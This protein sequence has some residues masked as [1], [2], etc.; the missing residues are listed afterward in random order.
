MSTQTLSSTQ[1]REIISFDPSNG[2]EIGRAPLMTAT[3]VAAA[4]KRTR[5]AQP[6]WSRLSFPARARYI[7]RAREIALAQ[8]EEIASLV[9]QETG[10]P[11]AE[12]ISMEIVPTLD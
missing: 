6:A 11:P 9:S 7:L 8:I 10:K 5:E 1:K 12:A 2:D 3:E 4:V